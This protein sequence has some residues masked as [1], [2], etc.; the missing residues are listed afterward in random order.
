[1]QAICVRGGC[2]LGTG[3]GSAARG[4]LVCQILSMRRYRG[5]TGE[6]LIWEWK[7]FGLV[8]DSDQD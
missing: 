1:M 2:W 3:E 4:N 7:G 5:R 8:R 6:S